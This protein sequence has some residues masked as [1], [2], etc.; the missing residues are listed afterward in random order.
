M[1]VL[2]LGCGPGRHCY[3]AAEG[4]SKVVGMDAVPTG[5]RYAVNWLQASEFTGDFVVG[6]MVALP[7]ADHSFDCVV[8]WNVVYHGTSGVVARAV[9]EIERVLCPG[10][11]LIATLISKRNARYGVGE[12]VEPDTFVIA[13]TEEA[14]QNHPHR[15]Y[16]QAGVESLLSGFAIEELHDVVQLKPDSFHWEIHGVMC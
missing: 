9:H 16:D 7:F 10:G 5:L 6:D 3:A 4:G 2:D 11:H 13:D 8:A 15:Y 1:R 12:E 14:E